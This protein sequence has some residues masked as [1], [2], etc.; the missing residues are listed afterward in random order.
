MP[1][2]GPA[3]FMQ[4]NDRF[5]LNASNRA[6]IDPNGFFDVIGH[7]SPTSFEVNVTGSKMAVNHRVLANLIKQ[8]PGYTAGQNVRLLSCSTGCL[9]DGFAQNLANYM[10]VTVEAPSDLLWAYPSGK[11]AISQGRW[12]VSRITGVRRLVP[13]LPYTGT[14]RTFEPGG[15][16]P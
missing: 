15:N 3:N 8:S 16:M 12:E 9:P 5:L 10:N 11:L 7:G 4:S 2:A 1:A 6:D 13:V 14:W